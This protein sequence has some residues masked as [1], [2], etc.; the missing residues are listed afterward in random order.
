M[1]SDRDGG[2][3]KSMGYNQVPRER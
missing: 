1:S 3:D 2:L